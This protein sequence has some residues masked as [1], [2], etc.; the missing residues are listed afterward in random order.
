[1]ENTGAATAGA[2]VSKVYLSTDNVITT[3]D[4]LLGSTSD[5][6][7][8]NGF[9]FPDSV[10]VTLSSSLTAGT[11]W[12]GVIADANGQVTESSEGD[13]TSS[14]VQITVT[15]PPQQLPN[16][17]ANTVSL[18]ST[19]VQAGNGTTVSYHMENTGAATAGASVS[20]VYLST[21]NVITTSDTLLGS[22]SDGSLTNGFYF[23]DSVN[24][25]L[26]SSLT[27]GTYWIGV[28]ADANGQVT[29]SSEGDNTS[30][31]VQITVT[32]PPQQLPNLV[33]NTVSLGS[34]TV[35]AGNGTTVSY[36]MEN[37]GAATAGAS[38]SKV[39][40]ST[41]N[42][43]TTSDTLLGSTS[44]GS[45]T[46]GFYFPDSVNVT[47]SSSLT[48]GTY[49]I[50]VI[51]DANGQVTESSEGDNTS[52][53]VQITVTA[54]P[55]Q[56][57]NLVANTV[58]LGSTTVQAGNGTT[59]SY[60]MENTG[61]A[62]A[63]A[64]VSKVYLSTDNVITTSDTL[65]GSTSDGSLTNGFYFPDSVNVT[66]SSS[67]TAGT[68]WIG[69][70]ADANGQVTESSEGDNTSSPVQITVTAPPQQL[71]N[72][73]ANTVSL[74]STT[75]QAG[76]G[77]TVS[78]HMENTGAATAGA[79]VSKVYLSTDNVITTSDTLL[80]STSDGS[81][82]NGFYF[83]DSVNVTLSSSLTA[84]TYWIGVI[85]DANG[86]VTESSEGDNTSSPVQITVTAP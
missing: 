79:S 20:K 28:I 8:T 38:V 83:P 44:D 84:G 36:H 52:S 65:L 55:Q 11:Y 86:Q 61:A 85:A 47:L 37:T 67:L 48:A 10:N 45:L 82:T 35:Q 2:S 21:D 51:A 18:G 1:M 15:A 81:L 75:V 42:V 26:S 57:P 68:Y 29:E 33:A 59:V 6:S 71:P 63:G 40:L 58:S 46:N 76:N 16:L 3:S 32:A 30:S 23:P 24:V 19:T 13:N 66:L 27:A 25:T 73:V 53:P 7:L 39:Y 41:D 43:I 22:T 31:P 62:T 72:L 54:P 9:Y 70:I 4:T 78:Y 50:G 12:I 64:S 77:T 14:P 17:V 69:V 80:G 34:T 74:G 49:W 60:H 5:G 56:L